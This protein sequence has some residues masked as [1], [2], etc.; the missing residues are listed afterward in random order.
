LTPISK[1]RM[2]PSLKVFVVSSFNIL[3][4]SRQI[5]GKLFAT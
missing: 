3:I 1:S 5:D 4:N 2:V